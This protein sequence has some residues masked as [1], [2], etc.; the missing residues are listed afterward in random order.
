MRGTRNTNATHSTFVGAD[1]PDCTMSYAITNWAMSS[2]IEMTP[3]TPANGLYQPLQ[4]FS[5]MRLKLG[6]TRRV[7]MLRVYRRTRA[8]RG[9]VTPK[10]LASPSS[11]LAA[12]GW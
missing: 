9:D 6:R 5:Q 2:A 7:R 11:G 3:R 1:R 4:A 12:C 8:W 10:H